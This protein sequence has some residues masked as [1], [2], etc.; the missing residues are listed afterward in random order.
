MIAKIVSRKS[1]GPVIDYIT[2]PDHKPRFLFSRGVPE[3]NIEAMKKS[4]DRWAMLQHRR[5]K[6]MAHVALSF[7]PK[8][9]NVTDEKMIAV[10]MRWAELMGYGNTQMATWSHNDHD[11]RHCH[12]LFN[13]VDNNG[14]WISDSHERTRSVEVCKTL[15][16]EFGLTM[17][18]GKVAIRPDRLKGKDKFYYEMYK[19]VTLAKDNANTWGDFVHKLEQVGIHMQLRTEGTQQ[20]INGI[21]FYDGEHSFAGS[22]LDN[23]LSMGQ[24][25]SLFGPMS[26]AADRLVEYFSI[27]FTPGVSSGGGGG[28]NRLKR[29]DD[30]DERKTRDRTK[31]K[32]PVKPR[33]KR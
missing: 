16:K 6:P 32:K 30:E 31:F 26:V 18:A 3:E 29:D 7:S 25:E 13:R 17:S 5:S 27:T 12:I 8:D 2:R 1:A 19:K 20:Q 11:Y 14:C 9:D 28:D 23:S 33:S 10:A 22:K 15:I 24:L 4:F 21:L